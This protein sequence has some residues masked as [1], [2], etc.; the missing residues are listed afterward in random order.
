MCVPQ[1]VSRHHAPLHLPLGVLLLQLLHVHQV[2]LLLVEEV[3]LRRHL[4][5]LHVLLLQVLLLLLLL[6]LLEQ[7]MLFRELLLLPHAILGWVHC[8]AATFFHSPAITP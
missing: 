2:L 5:H 7:Q 6:L 1:E 4:E 3:L 8:Q